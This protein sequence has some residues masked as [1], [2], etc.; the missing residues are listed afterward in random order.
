MKNP[1]RCFAPVPSRSL[2]R[3]FGVA[4]FALALLASSAQA[5][6]WYFVGYLLPENGHPN[7]NDPYSQAGYVW[8]RKD[9][10]TK[11]HFEKL[12]ETVKAEN[13]NASVESPV[14]VRPEVSIFLVAKTVNG[15]DWNGK[16]HKV[17]NYMFVR[18][19]DEAGLHRRMESEKK[20][21]P[22]IVD[23]TFTNVSRATSKL[24]E[25]G[26]ATVIGRAK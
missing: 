2:L 20:M 17:T 13:A 22:E 5:A 12:K 18:A 19:P 24:D 8:I 7:V 14:L 6:D 26:Q 23:Y 21:Y 9:E 11:S 3:Y 16:V 15:R 4:G 1:A 25:S 10:N